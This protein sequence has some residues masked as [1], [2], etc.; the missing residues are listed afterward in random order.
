MAFSSSQ[1]TFEIDAPQ[2]VEG[3][4]LAH[5]SRHGYAFTTITPSSHQRVLRRSD[6]ARDLRDV[7]G[8]NKPFEASLLPGALFDALHAAGLLA[9][10][11]LLWKS[12]VRVSSL[13]GDLFLHSGFPT[14]DADSVF[15]GPDTYRFARVVRDHLQSRGGPIER[16]VDIGAG[17][18]VGGIVLARNADC[19]DVVLV[20]IN[21]RALDYARTNVG[22]AGLNNIATRKSNLLDDVDGTFDL[23][24][25]NPPYLNDALGRTYRH[26]G[27]EFGGSLSLAIAR[28]AISRLAPGGS[29]LL[30]TGAAI[31]QGADPLRDAIAEVLAPSDLAW[32]YDELDPDVFGEELET[33]AYSK[34]DRIAAV[35]LTAQRPGGR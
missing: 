14:V 3:A 11:G 34:A 18:G 22:F 27:G 7:F 10:E 4:L 24:I 23:I 28:C 35:V 8:W 1:H 16:A 5:L 33:D 26:G 25:A 20:D 15:F 13:Q 31:V 32:S 19:R 21:D 2:Q 29:L 30:Y 6:I 9:A 12:R 17:S